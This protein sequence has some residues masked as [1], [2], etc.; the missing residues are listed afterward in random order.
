MT[1][2]QQ[3]FI[4]HLKSGDYEVGAAKGMW[5]NADADPSCSTWP[6]V[7]LWVAAASKTGSPDRYTFRFDLI[8]YSAAAPL[9]LPWDT[10]TGSRLADH[11]W[12]Q[13]P[14]PICTI[15]NPGWR[16]KSLYAPCDRGAELSEHS[17]WKATNPE[18][19]WQPTFTIVKYLQ[20]LY[21]TLH[22]P[23]YSQ[24]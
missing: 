21:E 10:T 14:P 16:G 20:F 18:Y 12:P 11:L 19:Y 8:G 22:T 13:G 5:G 24:S 7:Y 15:F 4:T 23:E 17:G 2:A 6:F 1:P 3:L 9:A